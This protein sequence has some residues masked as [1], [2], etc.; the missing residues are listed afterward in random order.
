M[1]EENYTEWRERFEKELSSALDAAL[2]GQQTNFRVKALDHGGKVE[3]IFTQPIIVPLIT[4]GLSG[5]WKEVEEF[6]DPNKLAAKVV[7][8]W[9]EWKGVGNG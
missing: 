4:G 6:K 3:I 1:A 7:E 9:L 2:E 5:P 8:R